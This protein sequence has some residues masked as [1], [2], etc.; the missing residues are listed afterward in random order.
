MV[1]ELLVGADIGG[2]TTRVAVA[3]REGDF[4]AVT[5]GGVGN[6]H[7]VGLDTSVTTITS[8]I[9]SALSAARDSGGPGEVVSVVIGL[10]GGSASLNTSG[11]AATLLPD[12]VQG[13]VR[14][15]SD[16]SVTFSSNT[17]AEHGYAMI[18]GTGAIAGRI[19]G[20]EVPT[21]RDGWGWL[22][23]DQGSGFWLGRAAVQLTM[24]QLDR[25][26]AL[27]PV[28]QAVL[29][30]LGWESSEDVSGARNALIRSVY[31]QPPIRLARFAPLISRHAPHD[32]AAA[33]IA[34]EAA[35][36]LVETLLDLD[37][38]PRLP[39]V[40]GGSVLGTDGPIRERVRGRLAPQ[41]L[42]LSSE[43]SGLVGAVWLAARCLGETDTG[44]HRLLRDTARVVISRSTP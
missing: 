31:G 35:D 13:P 7:L 10:A 42:H 41:F 36:L 20:M 33:R 43:A 30:D 5:V 19:C 12:G 23:G 29:A 9:A 14:I 28:A 26:E 25:E 16:L 37:P 39:I 6:P 8:T 24:S 27:G 1:Q 18:A 21:H 40:L 15:V 32:Q 3:S 44:V 4:R 34:D 17:P 22:L 38:D 11:F 2:T